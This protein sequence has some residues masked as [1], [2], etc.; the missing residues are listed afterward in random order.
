MNHTNGCLAPTQQASESILSS[1][2]INRLLEIG[3][4]VVFYAVNDERLTVTDISDSISTYGYSSEEFVSGKLGWKDL[5]HPDNLTSFMDSIH[6][7]VLKDGDITLECRIFNREG[8]PVWVACIIIPELNDTG[9]V[10]H[11]LC[12]IRDISV[13]KQNEKKLQK[14]NNN[15]EQNERKLAA[16]KERLQNFD[17]NFPGGTMFCFQIDAEQFHASDEQSWLPH[18]KFSYAGAKWEKYSNIRYEDIT[19]NVLKM[20]MKFDPDDLY[21]IFPGMYQSIA[22]YTEFHAEIRYHY[23]ENELR[24][25]HIAT[26]PR[27]ENDQIM[28]DGYVLDITERKYIENELAAYREELEHKVKIRTDEVEAVNEYLESLNQQLQSAN[29]ELQTINEE[30]NA[31]NEELFAKNDQLNIEIAARIEVMKRLEDSERKVRNFIHQS[32]EGIVILD[33]KGRIVEWNNAME[34]IMGVSREET[35]GKYEWDVLRNYFPK[36][37]M[38]KTL[39]Q[40]TIDY[41]NGSGEQEP[42]VNELVIQVPDSSIRYLQVSLFPIAQSGINYFGRI[43]SNI[44]ERKVAELKLERYRMQLETM[45]E[46]QTH[47]LLVTQ[48]RL[49]SL[50]NNLPG[51]IIYQMMDD[52]V[53][54]GWF[55][56]I[57]TCFSEIF[58]ID[59]EEVMVDPTPFYMCIHPDD[60]KNLIKSFIFANEKKYIDIEFR[61]QTASGK[62]KWIHM[63][64]SHHITDE[65]AREWNGFMMDVTERKLAIQELENIHRRQ[66]LLI[67]VQQI[68]QSAEN[69][70]QAINLTLAKIG[71]YTG[72][73]RVYI[74]EKNTDGTSISNTFEWCNYG[75][76]PAIDELQNLPVEDA[77]PLFNLFNVGEYVCTS[78]IDTLSPVMSKGLSSQ[79]VK[80]IISLPL[81]SSGVNYGFVGFDD[82]VTNREWNEGDVE[83]LKSLSRIISDTTRRNQAE[84]ALRLSQQVLHTVMNNIRANIFVTDFDTSKILYANNMMMEKAGN[85]IVGKEC[86]KVVRT[87]MTKICDDCPRPRLRNCDN[88]P[89]GLYRWERHDKLTGSYFDDTSLAIEWVDGRLVHLEYSVDITDRKKAEEAVRQ[90][91]EIYRQL[92]VAS[93]DAIITCGTGGLIRYASPKAVELL[94]MPKGVNLLNIQKFVQQHERYKVYSLLQNTDSEQITV[95]PDLLMVRQNGSEFIGEISAAPVKGSDIQSGSVIMVIRDVTQRKIEEKELINAKERAE[96]SDKLKSSFLANLSHEIRTPLNGIATLLSILNQD[97]ELPDSIREYIGI[98]NTNSEQLLKLINDIIDLAKIETK[99]MCLNP[100][101][102]S[103]NDLLDETYTIFKTA[104]QNQGK[105][106]IS[107]ECIKDRNAGNCMV[108][109]DHDRLKQILHSLLDNAIKFIEQ[110]YI[111]FGYRMENNMLEFFVKDTGIG[112]PESQLETIFQWF[113]QAELENN[114][115]FGGTG[116]GLTISRNLVQLMG[117]N[118]RVESTEGIGS[119]FYFTISYLPVSSKEKIFNKLSDDI[120]LKGNQFTNNTILIVEP[121]MLKYKYYERLLAAVGCTV[122]QAIN[123]QQCIDFIRLT[124]RVDAVIANISVFDEANAEEIKK[125]KTVHKNLPLILI[126]F[127]QNVKY[128]PIIRNS[129]CDVA[130]EEPVSRDEIVR[131]VKQLIK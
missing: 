52:S 54:T 95:L 38:Y 128:E 61:I 6:S 25:Y 65:G 47:E 33:N 80:S 81:V 9:Q 18:L 71:K 58:E 114:R 85:E 7:E 26:L 59:A 40:S 23:S 11:Y 35:L 22:E 110:G 73:S 92:T 84:T 13:K 2:E 94:G 36:D 12:K 29:M 87:G 67:E 108:H 79:G 5:L 112:I 14:I 50:S 57:S 123:I 43:I 115:R 105:A 104:L 83:M 31:T 64:S 91:E 62:N 103:I 37:E 88:F 21:R 55:S 125:I 106:H 122:Q 16:E 118:M 70:F 19:Q 100:E 45:V 1:R 3:R 116:L 131:T 41:I 24:W 77:Q 53:R 101:P 98:I 130:L 75:I 34:Q 60:R 51:G 20:F 124:N 27:K 8:N 46:I 90:S 86:W 107:L 97:P 30:L 4:E 121:V 93:P 89:T 56:H 15:I 32:F 126:G 68:I 17:N 39:H 113:R 119:S 129:L 82:C 48:E 127:R 96:E 120:S 76:Q 28:I 49:M 117:G 111:R 42:V 109:T 66:T 69:L 78:N 74:F 44:T 63:C 10:T 72:V 102:F 99:Q